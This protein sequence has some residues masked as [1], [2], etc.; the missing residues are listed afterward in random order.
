MG[1]SSILAVP[2]GLQAPLAHSPGVRASPH[3]GSD[4]MA[5][6]LHMWTCQE[7]SSPEASC[8]SWSGGFLVPT[9]D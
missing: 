3:E 2:F 4:S 7:V 5:P 9:G 6:D 8:C 1:G